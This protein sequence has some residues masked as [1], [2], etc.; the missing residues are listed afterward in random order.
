MKHTKI[1]LG[2]IVSVAVLALFF[3]FSS[4]PPTC[5]KTGGITVVDIGSTHVNAEV[6][7]TPENI[8]RGLMFRTSLGENA[9]M[10]FVF[11]R[12]EIYN[13]WMKNTKIPLDMLW[14]DGNR[15]IV[16]IEK[17]V[18]PCTGDPCPTYS[19]S[20]TARYVLEVNANFTAAHNISVGDKVS[21]C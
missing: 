4:R 7:D 9:G 19:P 10:L 20:K 14:I 11:D 13:F 21:L 3:S 15:R 6:A 5:Q 8:T 16:H 1:A 2:L 12:D 18:Q 17:N